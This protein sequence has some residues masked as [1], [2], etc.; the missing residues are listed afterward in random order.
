MVTVR[1]KYESRICASQSLRLWKPLAQAVATVD[2]H[3][4][5]R[6]Q[7]PPDTIVLK[8]VRSSPKTT[9]Q[10]H[11]KSRTLPDQSSRAGSALCVHVEPRF[12]TGVLAHG[13]RQSPLVFSSVMLSEHIARANGVELPLRLLGDSSP[14]SGADNITGGLANST[15]SPEDLDRRE[16]AVSWR[17]LGGCSCVRRALSKAWSTGSMI[18]PSAFDSARRGERF[19]A[20]MEAVL[21][22]GRLLLSAVVG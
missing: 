3:D 6:L 11:S 7:E 10:E 2:S 8:S 12:T 9:N 21:E 19:P 17:T 18:A 13:G 4:V 22:E 1:S 16:V 20:G 5:P 14:R 15:R